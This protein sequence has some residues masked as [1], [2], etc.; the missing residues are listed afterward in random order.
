MAVSLAEAASG[1][2]MVE[3]TLDLLGERERNWRSV[4]CRRVDD[5]EG[6]PER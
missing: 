5:L 3:R 4:S 2:D 6:L 1:T